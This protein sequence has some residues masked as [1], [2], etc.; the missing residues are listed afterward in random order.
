MFANATYCEQLVQSLITS[1]ENPKW[2][3]VYSDTIF[4]DFGFQLLFDID[5]KNK[6][7]FRKNSKDNFLVGKIHDLNLAKIIKTGDLDC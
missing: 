4:N 6:T 5:N 2:Q 7:I 3:R 1:D